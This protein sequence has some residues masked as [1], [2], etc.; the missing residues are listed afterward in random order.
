MLGE[1]RTVAITGHGQAVGIQGMGGIGKSVLAAAL[2]RFLGR[3]WTN[4][5]STAH[6]Q[7]RARSWC[8]HAEASRLSLQRR[9]RGELGG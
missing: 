5:T 8:G 4:S 7:T 6:C 9:E 1:D 2:A 3:K